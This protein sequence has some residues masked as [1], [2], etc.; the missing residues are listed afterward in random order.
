[1]TDNIKSKIKVC[2]DNCL[3][4]T[5][6]EDDLLTTLNFIFKQCK[7]YGL[8]LHASKC[9]LYATI[10][11]FKYLQA[12]IMESMTMEFPDPD[13]RVCVLTDASYRL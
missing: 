12:A 2:F 7:K 6:T 11:T 8:K 9:V 1:M 3:L 10:A 5:K 4:C 13:K